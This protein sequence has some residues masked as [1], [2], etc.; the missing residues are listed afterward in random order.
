M[1]DILK[2]YKDR[3]IKITKNQSLC[4]N[5]LTK[6]RGFDLQ[7]IKG[8][9]NEE[10]IK[11]LTNRKG[12]VLN[13]IEDP[14]KLA[15]IEL[16]KIHIELKQE[17]EIDIEKLKQSNI[18]EQ[19]E[20]KKKIEEIDKKYNVTLEK[21][22][23]KIE[24]KKHKQLS[25]ISSITSLSKTINK[26]KKETG[27][28]ELY[29][30]YPFIEGKFKDDKFVR[31]PLYL[32]PVSISI[33]GSNISLAHNLDSD[34]LLN[35][36]FLAAYSMSNET[37]LGDIEIKYDSVEED[38]IEEIVHILNK[39][40]IS[41]IYSDR[42]INKFK[43]Y[44][45][46][47]KPDYKIGSLFI[48]KYTVLGQFPISNS[49]YTD[50]EELEGK[51]KGE[52]LENLLNK[53]NANYNEYEEEKEEHGKLSFSEKDLYM[54][55][56][57]DYSQEKAVKRAS[58]AKNLVVYGPPGT[59]KSQ[60]ILNIIS[61]ALAKG[62]RILM[63][64]QKKAALDVIYNRLGLLNDKAV[65]INDANGDKKYFY[66]K[67]KN[68]LESMPSDYTD[69]EVDI[70]IEAKCVDKN[71]YT[72]ENL[73]KVLNKKI[74]YG[75][76]LQEMY[77]NSKSIESKDD[78]RYN[79][80]FKFTRKNDF[81]NYKYKEIKSSVDNIS[82]LKIKAFMNY[83]MIRHKN[84]FIEDVDYKLNFIDIEDLSKR[85]NDIIKYLENIKSNRLEDTKMYDGIISMFKSKKGRLDENSIR[86][87]AKDFN[88]KTNGYLLD[89]LN[90]K[91]SW[92]IIKYLKTRSSNKKQEELNKKIFDENE[93]EL[94]NKVIEVYK[95]INL[96]SEKISIVKKAT[97]EK[98]YNRLNKE[99]YNIEDTMI[100]LKSIK[101]ALNIIEK[102]KHDLELVGSL[103]KVERH[104]LN[105][106]HD[107]DIRIYRKNISRLLEFV[108]L[109]HIYEIEK[110][111]EVKE[112]LKRIDEFDNIVNQVR[113]GID[114]KKDLTIEY[115]INKWDRNKYRTTKS[116]KYSKF[117]YHAG[118]KSHL[119]PIRKYIDEYKDLVFDVF[120]CFLLNPETVSEVMPL[121]KGLFDVVIFDEASQMYIENGIPSIFR[122]KKVIISG[123]DKQLSP[124]DTFN[125][126]YI[127]EDDES[128]ET[129]VA[130]DADSLLDVAK[131]NYESVYLNYHY[132]SQS[133]ELINFS[134]HAFYDKRLKIAPNV[135]SNSEYGRPIERLK[136]EN[137]IWIDNTN[138]EEAEKVVELIVDLLSNRIN[139]E[140]IG[141]ITFNKK[142]Q[143]LIEG[144]LEKR[145]QDDE[146]FRSKYIEE[147]ERIDNDEDVSLFVKN[148]ES[149][150]GD[151]RDIIVFSTAYA[152]NVHGKVLNNFGP[153]N[154][155]G[156]ENRLNVAISRA[157]KK[158]YVVTSIEAEDL[159]VESSKNK[160]PRLFKEYLK[161]VRAV[162]DN[163]EKE[164]EL[165]LNSLL[166]TFNNRIE[167]KEH[168]SEFEAEVYDELIRKGYEVHKQVGV[169]GYR[170]DLAIYDKEASKY[171]LGIECD[172][173]TY[174]SSKSAR[175]RDIHRQRYLE[176]RGWKISRIWSTNWWRNP[177][178]EIERIESSV[179][180][181]A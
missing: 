146:E 14:Y 153:L 143:K 101:E 128:E 119:W 1:E 124:F 26:I 81:R 79:D 138:M 74:D 54:V 8:I 141:I 70:E 112:A 86:T 5:K 10:L 64:S 120:P 15:A 100:D 44:T 4:C 117:K 121:E 180:E 110:E 98:I 137:G 147:I 41:I 126:R 23:E 104:I 166:D 68:S 129:I 12:K 88:M 162:S 47:T 102:Y 65:I 142:Q 2:I 173:A 171:I 163:N 132:R 24:S 97:S 6:N 168:D 39:N 43:N 51:E 52:L 122:A 115:V 150:Q 55:S 152:K 177:T 56:N 172:G 78:N 139:K 33:K 107:N 89:K 76:S 46:K 149:V 48:K 105:S 179:K 131:A 71:I 40:N 118:K 42:S 155:I 7:D 36:V 50:Y 32:F 87:Y 17:Q 69:L 165:I 111:S 133:E 91:K 16:N 175:E 62:K 58:E 13:I 37:K 57:L 19:E 35:K 94:T 45:D 106:C 66:E 38:F 130:L 167:E 49:I 73:A 125:C 135:Y 178:K 21:E 170:I 176:S 83:K 114:K 158:I 181:L 31:A 159:S 151:E 169:S 30:G 108:T 140:T 164:Q 27:R 82:E 157:K 85:L 116:K 161:Y 96:I 60:T 145:A 29:I 93:I 75:I 11:W 22:E 154:N 95:D 90:N 34:I 25:N 28:E 113:H 123:D 20:L 174:H 99:F 3:L 156:G 80:F 160:G 77:E 127:D 136:I 63:V 61:D 18:L 84:R 59:G 103:D 134:N 53:D 144:L 92:N 109:D 67:I 148:I 72:L 9:N